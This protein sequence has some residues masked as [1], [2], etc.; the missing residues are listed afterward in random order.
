M[1]QIPASAAP[2]DFIPDSQADDFSFDQDKYS[3][4]PQQAAT[5]AEGAASAATFGISS[6]IERALGVDP[7]EIR[8][9]QEHNPELHAVGS[10]GG[11]IAGLFGPEEISAGALMT[12]AGIQGAAKFGLG[13]AFS[14]LAGRELAITAMPTLTGKAAQFAVRGAIENA[15]F[16]SG[17]EVGKMLLADPN[18]TVGTAAAGIGLSLLIGGA[19]NP[20]AHGVVAGPKALWNATI[21]KRIA[22]A[23]DSVHADLGGKG[24]S[25][26]IDQAKFQAD[27]LNAQLGRNKSNLTDIVEAHQRLGIEPTT[28]TLSSSEP[29]QQMEANLAKRPTLFGLKQADEYKG[30]YKKLQRSAEETM[31][32]A[33]PKSQAQVGREVKDGVKKVLDAE[34]KP[35]EKDYADI[36]PH[37]KKISVSED[38]I[39][40]AQDSIM[41]VDVV[42]IAPKSKAASLARRISEEINGLGNVDQ[43]KQYRTLINKRLDAAY[44]AGGEE[45]PVLQE[46]KN[47]LTKL[48]VSAIDSA[49]AR[50]EKSIQDTYDTAYNAM[51]KADAA[52]AAYQSGAPMKTSEIYPTKADIASKGHA[53]AI[54]DAQALKDL[55][56]EIVPKLKALDLRYTA[57]KQ[58]LKQLGVEAGIGNV[59]NARSLLE[60]F[61]KSSD[62]SF[63]KKIFDVDDINQLKFF[64]QNFPEQ[65]SEALK[66]KKSDILEA[67]TSLAQG[68]NK[69]LDIGKF[70]GQVRKLGPEAQDMIFGPSFAQ[71]LADIETVYHAIPGNPNPSGTAAALSHANVFSAQGILEN[72]SDSAK[73]ALLKNWPQL[74]ALAGEAG[75]GMAGEL[76]ALKVAHGTATTGNPSAFGE[77][78]KA[79]KQVIKG[80]SRLNRA[81]EDVFKAGRIVIPQN[82]LPTDKDR[83]KL[84]DKLKDLQANAAPL[85]NVGEDLG[86]YMPETQTA[87]AMTASNAVNFLNGIRPQGVKKY[88]LDTLPVDNPVQKSA[89]NRA[90]DIAEQPLIVLED[91]KNGMVTAADVG[92]LKNLY[93]G[94]YDRLSNKLYE[95]LM[96]AMH[97]EDGVPYKTRM[98]ISIFLGQPLD[99]TMT[100]EA[101]IAAQPKPQEAQ[102][103]AQNPT[104]SSMNK[105]KKLPEMAMTPGQSAEARRARV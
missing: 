65:F 96:T 90:L 91:V 6:G 35:I 7:N 81:A 1:D 102:A 80:E 27:E 8:A 60:K 38:M 28:G 105:L 39:K 64:K 93:P 46:A 48:R 99:S 92:T 70:L 63:A 41:G 54:S 12:K 26:P 16:Q 24:V 69:E 13:S 97:Q 31:L 82:M 75:G 56:P 72:L 71:R 76:A 58:K 19:F 101:I 73:Y 29:I 45:L 67:S 17:N 78:V 42:Q 2:P 22:S 3:T 43:L 37:L 66:F 84:D 4:L 68:K 51:K 33:T 25:S 30:I 36:T 103:Q 5:V 15:I 98:G 94:L 20:A 53:R 9:R 57:Y 34:L 62:E 87:L 32:D 104:N 85:F 100:P 47:Q 40:G 11:L 14:K 95:G 88:P 44:R 55:P 89:Y 83:K 61:A 59:G 79:I 10:V 52:E 49:A 74:Q 86:H 21:G 23:L 18:Q 77:M 50:A